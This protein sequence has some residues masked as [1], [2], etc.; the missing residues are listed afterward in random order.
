MVKRQKRV[1]IVNIAK[2]LGVNDSTVSRAL[3]DSP[4]V[5]VAMK[6]KVRKLAKEMGYAK[7]PYANGL[8]TGRTGIIE[9]LYYSPAMYLHDDPMLLVIFDYFQHELKLRGYKA[10]LNVVKND[11][12]ISQEEHLIREIIA[13]GTIVV[14][15]RMFSPESLSKLNPQHC[16]L[17]DNAAPGFTTVNFDMDHTLDLI[18]KYS[19]DKGYKNIVA[20][21][22]AKYKNIYTLNERVLSYN[23]ITRKYQQSL[24]NLGVLKFV[25]DKTDIVSEI[26]KLKTVPDIVVGL[27]V[28]LTENLQILKNLPMVILTNIAGDYKKYSNCL[29]IQLNWEGMVRESVDCLIGQLKGELQSPFQKLVKN[30]FVV[31]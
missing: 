15:A 11:G 12:V 18:M 17:M 1:T 6:A 21:M 31:E 20:L 2:K 22:S 27:N 16:V 8:K 26:G 10:I 25:K 13:D 28:R 19:I 3:S 23:R 7:N 9:L 24:A 30:S 4:E 29:F 5:S 14:K